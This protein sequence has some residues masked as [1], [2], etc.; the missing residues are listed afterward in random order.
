MWIAGTVGAMAGTLMLP[1]RT[2]SFMMITEQVV[3][4]TLL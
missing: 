2:G 1:S 4:A 3:N